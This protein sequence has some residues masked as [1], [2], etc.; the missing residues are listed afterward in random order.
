MWRNYLA[1]GLRAMAKNKAYAFINIF[2]L[3]VG[4][5][6]CLLLLLYVRYELSYDEWLP[7]AERTYQVQTW[8][9]N[10][11]NG[12]P[13]FV[14]A[15]PY[16][17][18]AALQK[19]FPQIE[20]QV[21]VLPSVPVFVKDGLPSPTED[22]WYVG[23][24]IL[25]VLK[26]PLAAGT[27][28][29]LAQPGNAAMS[30]TEAMKRFGTTAALGRTFTL[31]SKGIS[32]DY[33]VGA[34]I[35]D[36]PK[37]SHMKVAAIIRVDMPSYMAKEPQFFDC[38]G[39]Q[40][41]QIYARMKPGTDIDAVNA[42]LPAWEKRNIPD[43]DFGGTRFN[44]GDDA[45]WHFVNVKDV[46]LGKAQLGAMTPGNDRTTI[47]TFTAIALLILG[48]AVVNFTN[49]TTARASQRAREVALRKVLGADRQQLVI[50]FIG[51]SVIMTA[52]AMV[53][54]I[55]MLEIALPPVAAFLDSGIELSYFGT[56]GVILPIVALVLLVGVVGGAYPAFFLSRFQP[57]QVLKA[58][59]S[60]A[61]TPGSRRL[62]SALVVV[63]FAVSIGLIICTAIIYGQTVYARSV[64]PGYDRDRILQIDGLN[65][66]QLIDQGEAIAERMKRVPGVQAVGRSSFEIGADFENNTGVMVPGKVEPLTIGIAAVDEGFLDAMGM[67]LV[68]GRWYDPN[69]PRDDFTLPFPL[70]PESQ[71][72]MAARG[73]NVV[74][75]ELAAK[76]MGYSDPAQIIGKTFRAA[77][78]EQEYGVVPITVVGV[79]KDARFRS[80]RVPLDP[81]IFMNGNSGHVML[82]LRY[83]G[84]PAA[85]RSAAEGVWRTITSEV[86]FEAKFSEDVIQELYEADDARA[87][88]FAAFAL[89]SVVLGCAGL[90]GLAAFTA[91]RR[92][93]EIGIRK[94]L[95]ARTQDIVR[96]LVWQFSKPVVIANLIA[97]PVA[98]W[99]MRDWLNG[100]D[101]RIGLTPTPF[102]IAGLIA[103]A[104]AIGTVAGHALRVARTNPVHALRYE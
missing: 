27:A 18:G 47:I 9:P 61:D 65:R 10:P 77:L 57:S 28:Q 33:R 101:D 16:I 15:T 7:D 99:L 32:R 58:N 68:A 78:V 102:V 98:W 21:F 4:M 92:T 72:A 89:L 71:R 5:A 87:T 85:V 43:E 30:E 76:E 84:D 25:D 90:F 39:C 49:L 35:K 17:S 31:I 62:R 103:F 24:N 66:Y 64:D 54:A 26:L 13:G 55:A 52:V 23:D 38:W 50:Q 6:A 82:M 91:E 3:A 34:V 53:L 11:S 41:G 93:K 45:D 86:P 22:Y 96:L 56:G 100:F 83:R 73:A 42:Q 29:T 79:V 51:E 20:R 19:D 63:Q 67:K 36:L 59:K 94:V 46:H 97:W 40:A 70:T 81:M 80:V 2:G 48:I 104:I 14:Q 1:V 12:Q 8:F 95:G 44:A 88:A 69:R 60:S 74:I 37:N 75:N